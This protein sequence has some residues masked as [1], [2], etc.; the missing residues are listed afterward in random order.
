MENNG[1]TIRP[2]TFTRSKF[3]QNNKNNVAEIVKQVAAEMRKK[4]SVNHKLHKPLIKEKP[5]Y[6]I[7]VSKF[8]KPNHDAI[9]RIAKQVHAIIIE[10]QLAIMLGSIFLALYIHHYHADESI[11]SRAVSSLKAN[12]ASLHLGEW[13]EANV[14]K[15]FGIIISTVMSF[16]MSNTYGVSL[17]VASVLVIIVMPSMSVAFYVITF[18]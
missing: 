18:W 11:I 5:G 8:K 4:N 12:P 17:S 13:L 10:P 6:K 14:P 15:F 2:R 3:P 7:K 1:S 9:A 16:M